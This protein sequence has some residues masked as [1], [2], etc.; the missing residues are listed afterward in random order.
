MFSRAE[1]MNIAHKNNRN[2][3]LIKHILMPLVKE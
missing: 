1:P 3:I 2:E